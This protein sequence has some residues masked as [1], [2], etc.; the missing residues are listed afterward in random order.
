VAPSLQRIHL[1]RSQKFFPNDPDVEHSS[2]V[3]SQLPEDLW[4]PV[5]SYGTLHRPS[6]EDEFLM[7]RAFAEIFVLARSLSLSFQKQKN[8]LARQVS[9]DRCRRTEASLRVLISLSGD[10]IPARRSNPRR[11]KSFFSDK[12]NTISLGFLTFGNC[13]R[14]YSIASIMDEKRGGREEVY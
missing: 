6:T 12:T 1:N 9:F 4:R 7:S 11:K 14:I 10:V 5:H 3:S 8:S 13:S 2:E